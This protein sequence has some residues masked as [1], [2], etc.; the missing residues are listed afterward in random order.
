MKDNDNVIL[1]GLYNRTKTFEPK[2]VLELATEIERGK[3]K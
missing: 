2:N 3:E 1:E